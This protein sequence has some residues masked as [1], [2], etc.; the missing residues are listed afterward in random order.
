[1][2]CNFEGKHCKDSLYHVEFDKE[3]PQEGIKFMEETIK[4]Q[5]GVNCIEALCRNSNIE[6]F[7]TAPL[8]QIM[9]K[10]YELQAKLY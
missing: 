8:T 5:W 9:S 7:K 3:I 6:F 10:A 4:R 2:P 1:M